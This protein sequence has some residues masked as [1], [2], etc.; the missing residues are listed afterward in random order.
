MAT[1]GATMSPAPRAPGPRGVPLLGCIPDMRRD[2]LGF[3]TSVARK[4]G[5]VARFRLGP[6]IFN[7][8]T[9]ADVVQHVLQE[10]GRRY[11]K[12]SNWAPVRQLVG[13][14]L[15]GGDGATW[16]RQR[17]LV[18]PAFHRERVAGFGD[19]MVRETNRMLAR[20]DEAAA[21]GEPVEIT[22][23]LTALT[24]AIIAGAMFHTDLD[25]R[26]P[27]LGG[28]VAWLLADLDFRMEVP[29]YPG[30]RVPTNRNRRARRALADVRRTLQEIIDSR[31][32]SGSEGSDLLGMLMTA[33]DEATGDPMSDAQLRDELLTFFVAGH[34]TTAVLLAWLLV[35]LAAAPEW[36]RRLATE[37]A[38]ALG[39]RA[40]TAEDMT[41][42]PLTG[43]VIDETLR[44]HPPAWMT[45]RTATR[46]DVV[47]GFRIGRG[48]VVGVSPYALHRRAGL[49]PDPERFDPTRFKA[50]AV[51]A[52]PRFSYIPFGGGGHQCI[53]NQFALLEARLIT[54]TILRRYRL[55]RADP[56]PVGVEA[57]TT[58]RPAAPR[59]MRLEHRSSAPVASAT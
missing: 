32:R 16:L 35:E 30:F 59:R 39:D 1:I 2:Q 4:Y 55:E 15:F 8:V 5:P 34:E 38:A 23:D 41:A 20:W 44:L 21:Q 47:G 26:L 52:R 6:V 17:R 9:G 25:D 10:H 36:D 43:M 49:W 28:L 18:Q 58:L 45:S 51:A 53:G 40:A 46:D 31:R 19:L 11:V 24:M 50:D 3:V 12:G 57:S 27:A 7:L 14:G 29:L 37:A 48:E 42:L 33:R 22:H 13:D 56:G 54:A